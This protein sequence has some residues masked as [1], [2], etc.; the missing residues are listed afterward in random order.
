MLRNLLAPTKPADKA[1]KDLVDTLKTHLNPKSIIVAERFKFYNRVQL[2]GEALNAYVA[3]LR[4]MAEY[5]DFGQFLAE[6]LRD[7]FVCGLN[8]SSIRKRLLT[9]KN[10]TLHK[11]ITL[12]LSIDASI[13]ENELMTS[14]DR[15]NATTQAKRR[16]FRCDSENHMADSCR[17]KMYICRNCKRKGHLARACTQTIRKEKDSGNVGN[18]SSK[19]HDQQFYT[20]PNEGER[21][22][23]IHFIYSMI[24]N[25]PYKISLLLQNKPHEC[26]IDT[27]AGRSIMSEK[28]YKE[29]LKERPMLKR[30]KGW[31]EYMFGIPV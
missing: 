10:L 20:Q 16:C 3:Q 4:K 28:K 26:E 11:A 1:Y 30:L 5:C 18:Y 8:N 9:E 22:D 31:L 2:P 6:A 21:E 27:G 17:F 15:I 13:N 12:A 29:K 23:E 19:R 24:G 25:N 14:S 7:R